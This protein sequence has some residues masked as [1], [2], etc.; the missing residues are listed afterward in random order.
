MAPE[1]KALTFDTI[2]TVVDYRST[3]LREG[4]ELSRT[5]GLEV[6]WPAFVTAWRMRRTTRTGTGRA[7][8]MALDQPG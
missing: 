1:I 3:M 2:G 7:G 8:G 6:D 5:K 4:A